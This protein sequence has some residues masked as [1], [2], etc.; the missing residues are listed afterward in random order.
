MTDC[1]PEAAV[2]H[3]MDGSLLHQNDRRDN[4]M[5]HYAF[6]AECAI[7][8]FMEQFRPFYTIHN[9]RTHTAE[10]MLEAMTLY[11]ELLG[12][13]MP[14]LS[15]LIGISA[16]PAILFQEHPRRRYGNDVGYTADE[17]SSCE[18]FAAGLVA[19]VVDAALDGKLQYETERGAL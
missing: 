10:P 8:A 12:I 18:A 13:L 19:R 11:N 9:P 7:K 14:Q 6:S 15:L 3:Y 1:F 17:L 5:C 2:R 4:A 16:P